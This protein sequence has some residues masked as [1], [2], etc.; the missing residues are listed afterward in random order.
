MAFKSQDDF[1]ALSVATWQYDGYSQTPASHG[2][3]LGSSCSINSKEK[4]FEEDEVLRTALTEQVVEER[5]LLIIAVS[6]ACEL[7]RTEAQTAGDKLLASSTS[8]DNIF[9]PLRRKTKQG[10]PKRFHRRG[11][12]WASITLRVLLRARESPRSTLN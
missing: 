1:P 4:S 5:V 11:S 8:A 3:V 7:G 9:E 10:P 2:S 6:E 12:L